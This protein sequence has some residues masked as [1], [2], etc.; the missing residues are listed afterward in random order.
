MNV[1]FVANDLHGLDTLQF[2]V[3]STVERNR[4]YVLFVAND[5]HGLNTLQ[6]TVDSTVERNRLNVLFV[7]NDLHRLETL[8]LTVEFTVERNRLNVLIVANDLDGLETLQF[9][10]EFTVE[11]NRVNVLFVVMF[12]LTLVQSCTHVV[13]VQ[14]ILQGTADSGDIW[15]SHTMK[16]LGCCLIFIRRISVK[17]IVLI[18]V[19]FD[20]TI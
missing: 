1:L 16:V 9:T 5:L 3:E 11:R 15:W 8:Q 14:S 10:V 20:I 17:V 19:Y 2:T 18:S 6:F 4:L 12:V 7:A 13:T